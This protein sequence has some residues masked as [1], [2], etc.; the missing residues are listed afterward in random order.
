MARP[1][2]TN[3]VYPVPDV[4]VFRAA[5]G[6]QQGASSS[7]VTRTLLIQ[8]KTTSAARCILSKP[9]TSTFRVVLPPG[10]DGLSE[11]SPPHYCLTVKP[12]T[13]FKVWQSSL[14]STLQ[15]EAPAAAA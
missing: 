13:A 9:N 2:D 3:T 8:N 14:C 7:T 10:S 11:E 15:L 5:A 1:K 12:G 6:P 4:V